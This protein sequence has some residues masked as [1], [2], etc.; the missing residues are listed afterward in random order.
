M[1]NPRDIA[2]QLRRRRICPKALACSSTVYDY[3]VP[4]FK[5]NL[6]CILSQL[7]PL[8]SVSR[9][10]NN[11]L[12]FQVTSSHLTLASQSMVNLPTL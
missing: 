9:F 12:A 7:H 3:A 5:V 6:S 11:L 8:A 4:Q 2:R 1:V 10:I